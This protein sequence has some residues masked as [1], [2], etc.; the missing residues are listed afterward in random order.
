VE[1]IRALELEKKIQTE[2][3]KKDKDTE[4]TIALQLIKVRSSPRVGWQYIL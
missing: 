2:R 3:R 4:R 1:Q